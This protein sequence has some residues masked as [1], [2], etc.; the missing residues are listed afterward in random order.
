[1]DV[2]GTDTRPAAHADEYP[3]ATVSDA[4]LAITPGWLLQLVAEDA[5]C[6]ECTSNGFAVQ[7]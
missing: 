6:E 1:M 5:P 7:E 4:Y 3:F 2:T